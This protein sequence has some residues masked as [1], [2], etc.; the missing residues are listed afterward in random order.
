MV[1]KLEIEGE[2]NGKPRTHIVIS[3]TVFT[4]L[5]GAMF[6]GGAGSYGVANKGMEYGAFQSCVRNTKVAMQRIDEVER[7]ISKNRKV[8]TDSSNTRWTI[9]DQR[10]FDRDMESR[11]DEVEREIRRAKSICQDMHS[12]YSGPDRYRGSE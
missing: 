4:L 1:S 12:S 8:L 5:L 7:E 6:G 3:P 2:D 9:E 10:R 11:F